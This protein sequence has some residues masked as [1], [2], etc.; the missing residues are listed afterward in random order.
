MTIIK[1]MTKPARLSFAISLV[2]VVAL[3]LLLVTQET[4]HG[5][6]SE[7]PVAVDEIDGGDNIVR[8]IW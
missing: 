5:G 8:S 1:A 7:P 6:V 3:V 2:S 4:A